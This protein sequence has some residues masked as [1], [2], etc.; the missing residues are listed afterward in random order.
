MYTRIKRK[1][2]EILGIGSKPDF[3]IIGA[4]KSGT[5]SLFNYL[6]DYG[7][8]FTPPL[9]K[10]LYFF[11]EHFHKGFNS[12][13]ANFP[14]FKK[15]TGEATPDYL[16]YHGAPKKIYEYNPNIKLVVILRNPTERAFSQ[17]CHQN[18]TW[19]TK[20]S[21]PL[22]FSVAIREEEKRFHI[23]EKSKYFYEYKYYSY[24]KRGIYIE[25]IKNWLKF[26]DKDKIHFIVLDELEQNFKQE[27]VNLMTFLNIER[28][29]K[30]ISNKIYNPSPKSEM[31]EEDKAYLN[32]FFKSY[33]QELFDFLGKENIWS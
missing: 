30:E 11:T 14:V 4:Q 7:K 28:N 23:D 18:Y 32:S 20:A 19:K 27:I 13:E 8:N 25:Q 16:F 12:Y 5:T 26:F 22:S 17:Y 3:L 2:K 33:N 15:V 24:K 6:I 9:Q 21:D 29:N 31:K 10:E 1:F